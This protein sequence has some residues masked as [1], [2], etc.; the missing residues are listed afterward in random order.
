MFGVTLSLH[1]LL[2]QLGHVVTYGRE[3][4]CGQEGELLDTGSRLG[5]AHLAVVLQR[6]SPHP[7]QG[8]RMINKQSSLCGVAVGG[9]SVACGMLCCWRCNTPMCGLSV[10][11]MA[12]TVGFAG[13]LRVQDAGL[14]S[15]NLAGVWVACQPVDAHVTCCKARNW[16]HPYMPT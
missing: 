10:C 3:A 13:G 11:Y 15:D 1:V 5:C 12:C 14:L 6:L 9:P 7:L 16:L 8:R 4:G 2:R